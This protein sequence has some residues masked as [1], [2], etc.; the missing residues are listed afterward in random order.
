M[1]D[2]A[3][4]SVY[5]LAGR[6]RE[7]EECLESRRLRI[8]R[9]SFELWSEFLKGQL[10]PVSTST[11]PKDLVVVNVH[12]G[13]IIPERLDVDVLVW[14]ESFEPVPDGEQIPLAEPIMFEVVYLKIGGPRDE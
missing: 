2:K 4:R 10:S 12:R 8:V 6:I 9:I 5:D 14:S 3:E 1:D 13:E 7:R 11:C